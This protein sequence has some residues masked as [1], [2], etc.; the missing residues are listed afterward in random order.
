MQFIIDGELI[1]GLQN[2]LPLQVDFDERYWHG[3]RVKV[4]RAAASCC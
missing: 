2:Y 3:I 4:S 1:T